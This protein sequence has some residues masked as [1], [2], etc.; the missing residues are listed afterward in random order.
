MNRLFA[1]FLPFL[2]CHTSLNAQ[3][4]SRLSVSTDT[5]SIG[6]INRS[7]ITQIYVD[8]SGLNEN[9]ELLP[10]LQKVRLRLYD[11]GYSISRTEESANFTLRLEVFVSAPILRQTEDSYTIRGESQ[12]IEKKT[13]EGKKEAITIRGSDRSVPVIREEIYFQ[14]VIRMKLYQ[15]NNNRLIW[16]AESIIA[17]ETDKHGNYADILVYEPLRYFLKTTPA[18]PVRNA[19][20]RRH[21]R[22]IAELFTVPKY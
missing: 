2:L 12:T 16:Q 3:W 20:T 7:K 15:L 19:Y 14:K 13:A 5:Y 10:Y 11:L 8:E 4:F 22:I 17:D 18:H 9:L 6:N 21:R 1:F